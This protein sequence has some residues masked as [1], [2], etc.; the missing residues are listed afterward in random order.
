MLPLT[1]Y[2]ERLSVR[3]GE[4]LRFHLANATGSPVSATVVRVRCADPNP[5]IGGITTE[6][7][8]LVV[9]TLAQPVPQTV[10]S[11]SYAVAGPAGLFEG[12]ADCTVTIRIHPTL[13]LAR[14][15][16]IVA[17]RGQDDPGQGFELDLT[18]SLTLRGWVGTAA[19]GAWVETDAPVPLNAW[20]TV[21]LRV[22]S[23]GNALS[24]TA[25]PVAGH[26]SI[27]RG[28]AA[29]SAAVALHGPACRLSIASA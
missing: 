17:C 24:L 11:G 1:G 28:A 26:A 22:D 23:A 13:Q 25:A 12:L 5:L 16:V 20:T 8:P 18:A 14:R 4:T 15:Q 21:T 27:R 2:A 29:L 7:V 3:P 10:P 6:P 9:T 19:G